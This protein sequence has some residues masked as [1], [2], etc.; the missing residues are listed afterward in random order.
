[1]VR[2]SAAEA[3]DAALKNERSAK[4]QERQERKRRIEGERESQK[5][6]EEARVEVRMQADTLTAMELSWRDEASRRVEQ[7]EERFS[8]TLVEELGKQ[9]R[10][11]KREEQQKGR[12]QLE[13]Q[14]V[15]M[16]VELPVG[17]DAE[18]ESPD[19]I[20]KFPNPSYDGEKRV[21]NRASAR[22]YND[23]VDGTRMVLL[24]SGEDGGG[25][26]TKSGI[27]SRGSGIGP[28]GQL[29]AAAAEI[30]LLGHFGRDYSGNPKGAMSLNVRQLAM[31]MSVLASAIGVVSS[32]M[33]CS[34]MR[35][36]ARLGGNVTSSAS[37]SARSFTKCAPLGWHATQLIW[38]SPKNMCV[39]VVMAHQTASRRGEMSSTSR[40]ST[41]SWISLVTRRQWRLTGF[42]N[43]LG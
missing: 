32:C 10:R 11:T 29:Q 28:C 40:I 30:V 1:V 6:L 22:R 2:A 36:H 3:D 33:R 43:L 34:W 14:R 25:S 39:L 35:S 23:E 8:N 31:K 24:G 41:R 27:G 38:L 21:A 15:R 26:K 12:E 20:E 7:A 42:L 5:E 19:G 16:E 37:T 4:E 9:E 17:G 13:K 18:V